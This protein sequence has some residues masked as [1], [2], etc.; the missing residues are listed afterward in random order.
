MPSE[1]EAD[2]DAAATGAGGH[3]Y[4]RVAVVALPVRADRSHAHRSGAIH[5]HISVHLPGDVRTD[6]L[7]PAHGQL[8]DDSP[9]H[10][11]LH[12]RVSTAGRPEDL[13]AEAR[14]QEHGRRH[15]ARRHLLTTALLRVRL[16][17]G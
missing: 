6:V 8:A 12:R 17:C 2:D 7:H 9:H 5:P 4:D 14:L 10:R 15:P 13:H 11:P 16:Q 3:R 1:A